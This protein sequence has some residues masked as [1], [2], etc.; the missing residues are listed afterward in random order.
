MLN[1]TCMPPTLWDVDTKADLARC[2]TLFREVL[3]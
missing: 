1:L 2:Q 3:L